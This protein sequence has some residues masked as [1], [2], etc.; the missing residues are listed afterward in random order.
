MSTMVQNN[1]YI[2]EGWW[3]AL[4]EE[5]EKP[6]MRAL[7]G[8]LQ[9]E[10]KKGQVIYPLEECIF[11]AFVMTPFNKVKVVILGQDPYHNPGQAHGLSFSVQPGVE[12]PPSLKNI[13]KEIEEDL[14]IKPPSHGHLVS[15]AKQGVL[16]LNATLTVREN[17]PR[18]HYGQGWETFTDT[19]I[20]KLS[21]RKE[22]LV[23]MLWGKSAKEKISIIE[24]TPARHLILEAP[25]PS[26]FSVHSGFFGCKH[27][28]KANSFLKEPI[29]WRL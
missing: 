16:L 13:Y 8:F 26:P 12:P 4:G 20:R 24:N 18:S 27:F 7:Q 3:E 5:F 6:Y 25:H 11:N 10:V 28:S 21:Q 17:E 23:F 19:A 1:L 29:D 2:E 22:P 9:E 14:G 15:W